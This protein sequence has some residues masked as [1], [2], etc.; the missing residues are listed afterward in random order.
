MSLCAS[1]SSVIQQLISG[2]WNYTLVMKAYADAERTQAIDSNTGIELQQKVWVE[3]KTDG[4]DDKLIAVVTDSCWA[5]N[6]ASP[7]GNV[8]YNLI[9]NG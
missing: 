5:T 7:N 2:T 6:Q 3:L 8:R 9:I 4:L 1:C